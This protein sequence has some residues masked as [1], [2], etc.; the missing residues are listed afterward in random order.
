MTAKRLKKIFHKFLYSEFSSLEKYLIVSF[1]YF[2]LYYLNFII[3]LY[4]S[5][6][7]TIN[8]LSDEYFAFFPIT[9]WDCLFILLFSLPSRSLLAWYNPIHLLWPFLCLLKGLNQVR[10][11]EWR[12]KRVTIW[13][14]SL[15]FLVS[16]ADSIC[17]MYGQG[18]AQPLLLWRTPVAPMTLLDT[19]QLWVVSS[20]HHQPYKFSE[21]V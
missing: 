6:I 13:L 15:Y 8:P 1:A 16:M 21:N 12:A 19:S 11:L 17:E 14:S 2:K 4:S 10:E 5:H 9:F 3:E 20:N 7:A 18:M